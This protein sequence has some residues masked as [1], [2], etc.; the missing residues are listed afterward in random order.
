[1]A[2]G[3]PYTVGE[4]RT[5]ASSEYLNGRLDIYP[6]ELF[7]FLCGEVERLRVALEK[8]QSRDDS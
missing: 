7:M 6:Y 8:S 5:F 1:M 2:K 3:T 4:A